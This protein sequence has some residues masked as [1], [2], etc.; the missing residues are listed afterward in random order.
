MEGPTGL[1]K[2]TQ[3]I[4]TKENS[5]NY[6]NTAFTGKPSNRK[7]SPPPGEESSNTC[8]SILKKN[9]TSE[10]GEAQRA[11]TVIIS[12]KRGRRGATGG[13][14]TALNQNGLQRGLKGGE[15]QFQSQ[16][17]KKKRLPRDKS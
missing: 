11:T 13:D 6:K 15:F 4:S 7:K 1:R 9:K 14:K 10:G 2:G 5:P 12:S 8:K 16:V 3:S 17:A